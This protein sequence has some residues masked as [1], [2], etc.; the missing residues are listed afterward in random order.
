F[1]RAEFESLLSMLEIESPSP[2]DVT[3]SETVKA[4]SSEYIT[5][6]WKKALERRAAD[7]EGAITLSRTLLESVCKHILDAATVT[8]DDN[9]DLPR[10]YTLA[11]RQLN[12]SPSEH[13]EQS[14]SRL[15]AGAKQSLRAWARCE[16]ATATRT[17]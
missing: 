8:Y 14:S 16:I 12:P 9:A 3:I 2:S 10:L 4:V 1:V 15:L 6:V 7:P 13:T 17:A 5:E 11:T